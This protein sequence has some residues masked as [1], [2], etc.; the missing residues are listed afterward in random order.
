MYFIACHYEL[1]M[2]IYMNCNSKIYCN[3]VNIDNCEW[4]LEKINAIA[5]FDKQTKSIL[6]LCSDT[7]KEPAAVSS[8]IRVSKQTILLHW[9]HYFTLL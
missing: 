8:C 3:C 4:T 1:L 7:V 5:Y 2:L 9:K 6:V